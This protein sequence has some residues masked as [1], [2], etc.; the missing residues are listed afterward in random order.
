VEEERIFE[1][2]HNSRPKRKAEERN[3]VSS[4]NDLA[5]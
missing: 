3:V 1:E 5:K 2:I 4:F